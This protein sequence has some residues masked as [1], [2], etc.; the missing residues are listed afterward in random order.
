MGSIKPSSVTDFLHKVSSFLGVA[1]A[2][3]AQVPAATSWA[4]LLIS[5]T[6]LLGGFGLLGNLA[7]K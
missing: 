5:I 3:A 6:G 4:G 2:V 7:K 1:A